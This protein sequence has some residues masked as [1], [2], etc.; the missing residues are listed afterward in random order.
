MSQ[1]PLIDRYSHVEILDCGDDLTSK[2]VCCLVEPYLG[3]RLVELDAVMYDSMVAL[4]VGEASQMIILQGNAAKAWLYYH[5]AR[6]VNSKTV[7]SDISTAIILEAP[8]SLP[9]PLH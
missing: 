5:L 1:F 4:L 8:Q 3:W 7:S 9:D 2:E 6:A